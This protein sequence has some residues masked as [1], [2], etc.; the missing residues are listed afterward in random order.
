M[1]KIKSIEKRIATIDLRRGSQVT[2]RI[3][4]RKLQ[5][6]RERILIRDEYT[7]RKCGHVSRRLEV[8]HITPLHMGGVEA[9]SNRQALCSSCHGVKTEGETRAREG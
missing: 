1:A 4:G 2:T 3:T 7:C 6:I 5:R 8:D 9:D